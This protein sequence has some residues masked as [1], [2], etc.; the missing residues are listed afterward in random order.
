MRAYAPGELS[1]DDA[2]LLT[3]EYRYQVALPG[4]MLTWSVFSDYGIG[5]INHQPLAGVVDNETLLNGAGVGLRWRTGADLE[6]ALMAAWRGA[7]L[8][9]VDGD[10]QPRIFF[11]C[12]KGL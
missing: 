8:P 9:T 11:Q 6:F 12:I 1:A 10:P 4:S 5:S 2:T 7:H 3:L